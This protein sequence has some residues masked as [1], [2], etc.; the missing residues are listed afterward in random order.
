MNVWQLTQQ[1]VWVLSAPNV[2]NGKTSGLAWPGGAEEVVLARVG[3]APDP[4]AFAMLD[5]AEPFALVSVLAKK[6]EAE[7]PADLTEEARWA[8][9]LFCAN[10]NDQAGGAPIVGASRVSGV[11]SSVGRGLLEV[12][13]LVEAAIFNLNA[14][15]G[16]RLRVEAAPAVAMPDEWRGAVAARALT[17]SGGPRIPTQPCFDSV[18]QLLAVGASGDVALTWGTLP[19]RWDLVGV[20]VC[21]ASGTTA[22]TDP[23]TG[24]VAT[25]GLVTSYSDT[26]GA[27]TWSY[28]IF[29][30][31]D[32]TRNPLDGARDVANPVTDFS[33][34]GTAQ[35]GFVYRA[36]TV[37]VTA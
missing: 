20:R 29:F 4:S 3:V 10:A 11:G 19:D 9:R 26:P 27:G 13:P 37:T 2:T 7:H 1:L 15:P 8:V 30:A 12:E 14:L 34:S 21:R 25:T 16:V 36:A 32:S 35:G 28:A 24:I 31:F 6:G 22:P 5:A 18:Q 33:G 23:T 17:V